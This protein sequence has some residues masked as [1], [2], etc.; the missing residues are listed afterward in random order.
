MDETLAVKKH[1][2]WNGKIEVV[3]K[4]PVSTLQELSL[5]YTPGVADACLAIKENKEESYNLTARNN[6]V[7][8]ITDGT[9]ILGLG[10]IGPEA[11]MPVMEGKCALFKAYGDVNAVPI[12]LN[13]KDS[14]EIIKTI[15]YLQPSFGGIN[16]E[17]ISA[18]RCFEIET[19]L[20]KELDI[21][22][23]HDDQHG[24]AVVVGAALINS[25]KIVK[26]DIKDIKVVINGPGAAG[27]AIGKYLL[28]MG[29]KDVV[30]VDEHGI[31][32]RYRTYSNEN[33]K[34]LSTLSNK[35]NLTGTLKDAIKD[36]DL[37]VGVSV[38]NVLSKELVRTMAKDAIVFALANP[39]SEIS[40][41]DAKDAGARIVGTGSSTNPNQINN[42]LVFPGIFKG[43]LEV[44]ASDINT[45]MMIAASKG[46]AETVTDEQLNEEYILPYAFNK[47]AH[48]N[49]INKVKQAAIDTKV[50]RLS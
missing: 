8:V 37:F 27:T 10:D 32:D 35:E 48:Q 24:T 14:E 46:I 25:L 49:V 12:C 50:N 13:T 41:Q 28:N 30:W 29:V 39:I 38:G 45:E 5:A 1:R 4:A 19:R 15:K 20:K 16:L 21:P 17:D 6:M 47:Q 44:R 26:K 34:Q 9:A 22:V 23:F 42:V 2:E 31:V 11:G 40:Y 18:P 36:K 43:A 33:L 3:A 7:A